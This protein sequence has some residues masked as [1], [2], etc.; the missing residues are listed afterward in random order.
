MFCIGVY[1]D[2]ELAKQCIAGIQR[3][4]PDSILCISDGIAHPDLEKFC[5]QRQVQYVLGSRLKLPAFRGAWTER[6]FLYFLGSDDPLMIKIDPDTR[7][8]RAAVIPAAPV[9]AAYRQGAVLNGWAIGF[10]RDTVSRIV[11]SGFLHDLK[12]DSS[13]YA[14]HRFMPPRLREGET[15]S[16]EA[17][18][19]QDDITTDVVRRLGIVP[20]E[21]DEVSGTDQSAAF[22]HPG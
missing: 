11:R 16:C 21:W 2:D 8:N 15:E 22:Y 18:A 7:V 17:V 14:Y 12:Y 9:F 19:L 4:Y 13:S 20:Q 5:A 3:N 6:F 1:R 10:T